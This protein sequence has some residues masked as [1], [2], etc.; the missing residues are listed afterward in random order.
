MSPRRSQAIIHMGIWFA[1]VAALSGMAAAQQPQPQPQPQPQA[2]TAPEP[3]QKNQTVYLDTPA[4]PDTIPLRQPAW[5]Y[6]AWN[7][8]IALN[9]PALELVP[10]QFRRAP[11]LTKRFATAANSDLGVWETFKEKREIFNHPGTA[12][13]LTWYSPIDYGTPRKGDQ[14]VP[15]NPKGGRV[16]HQNSGATTPPDALD[17]TVEVQS[18]SLEA[19]YPDGTPN[20]IAKSL[21]PV[22]T[23]RVWRGQPSENNPIVYEVKLNYDYF[24]YVVGNGF[25]VDNSSSDPTKNAVLA[26]ALAAN[27]HL[28]IRTSSAMKPGGANPAVV[29]YRA[30]DVVAGFQVIN[31]LYKAPQPIS[32]PLPPPQGSIQV[33]AAWIK[34][35]GATAKPSDF[36]TW[37]TAI[38]Q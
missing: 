2:Q 30:A 16:L 27:I 10:D 38:A 34:L 29:N 13:L 28:P 21:L 9:W 11:E 8:F 18:Q 6:F 17:E 24:N 25:N 36:P 1:L 32:V 3:L 14:T 5:D 4:P 26:A 35:G 20:P 19:I 31:S 23:P 22:V 7:S 37:H 12:K 15:G 33:K